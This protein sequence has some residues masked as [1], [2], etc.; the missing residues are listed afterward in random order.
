M[1]STIKT[2][3]IVYF[4]PAKTTRH[5]AQ[6]IAQTLESVN[7]KPVLFDLE[8]DR[9]DSDLLDSIAST[10]GESLLF[11][12]S[13]VYVSHA[14]PQVMAFISKL[15]PDTGLPVIPFATWGGATSGIALHEMGNALTEKGMVVVGAAKILALHSLMWQ[16]ENPLGKGRP[17]TEDDKLIKDLVATVL[18]KMSSTP[19]EGI[20]L[21]DLAYY[22]EPVMAEMQ[23]ITLAMAKDHFPVR[24]VDKDACTQ[25]EEC[26]A[27]CP[28]NAITFSPYPDFGDR[29]VY[30]YNCVRLCPEEA[31]AADFSMLEELI[32][33]R[34]AQFKETP[35]S[36]IFI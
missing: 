29:C 13:P 35:L 28:T 32:R 18:K 5:V 11:I 21:T 27:T 20:P 7:I 23:K 4:S 16:F 2:A 30:C 19:S 3:F 6:I 33:T 10:N 9:D 25:C 22:P 15:S 17:N 8:K 12:G 24:H 1:S 26:A 36:S 34:A 14:V 31:I